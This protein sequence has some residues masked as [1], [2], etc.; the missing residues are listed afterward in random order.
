M[1]ADSYS[2]SP[3][4]K[5]KSL[6][7]ITEIVSVSTLKTSTGNS[8]NDFIYEEKNINNMIDISSVYVGNND[9]DNDSCIRS[10]NRF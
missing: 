2:L 10:I 9:C 6:G 3:R 7:F 5:T 4:T 8:I 1:I